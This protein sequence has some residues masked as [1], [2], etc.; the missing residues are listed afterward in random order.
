M[1]QTKP[2]QR[3]QLYDYHVSRGGKMVPF[4]GW[5]MPAV[6]DDQS[7]MESAL[8]TRKALSL[9]DVSHMMQVCI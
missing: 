6:Y 7:I 5:A 1:L 8:H 3:T 9:F 2:L 4:A